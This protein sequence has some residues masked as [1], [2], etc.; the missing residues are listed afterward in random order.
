MP[1]KR[2]LTSEFRVQEKHQLYSP[3]NQP[4]LQHRHSCFPKQQP[5]GCPC[6]AE[7]QH[8]LPLYP[9]FSQHIWGV[10]STQSHSQ[11]GKYR[12]RQQSHR[13]LQKS[14]CRERTFCI[15]RP[16]LICYSGVHIPLPTIPSLQGSHANKRGTGQ[17]LPLLL[18]PQWQDLLLHC[19]L[20][21]SGCLF[22]DNWEDFGTTSRFCVCYWSAI[23]KQSFSWASLG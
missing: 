19:G 5:W 13:A 10:E 8:H 23:R 11:N 2:K 7:T 4:P 1:P 17:L 9:S 14:C 20:Q 3:E 21:C 16:K 18:C 15:K 12:Q 6:P 22:L